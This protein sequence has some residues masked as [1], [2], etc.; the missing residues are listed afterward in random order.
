M[1]DS[2]PPGSTA[3]PEQTGEVPTTAVF[4]GQCEQA[5]DTQQQQQQQQPPQEQQHP[6][7]GSQPEGFNMD[8]E[9]KIT[10]S[11]EDS[12]RRPLQS[13]HLLL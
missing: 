2:A 7:T 6:G 10:D 8:Q 4:N 12:G 5:A 1:T 13:F 9:M 3:V 11:I